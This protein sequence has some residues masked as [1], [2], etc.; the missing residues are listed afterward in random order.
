MMQLRNH[1]FAGRVGTSVVD[2][3]V[4]DRPVADRPAVE[5]DWRVAADFEDHQV[6]RHN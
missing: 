1:W 2:R 6:Q 4:V 5:V 3:R